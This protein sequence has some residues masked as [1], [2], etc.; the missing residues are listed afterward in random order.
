[1]RESACFFELEHNTKAEF[2]INL[3]A[4]YIEI[5]KKM[6]MFYVYLN[7]SQISFPTEKKKSQM[8]EL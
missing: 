1:L 8:K 7:I 2:D 3:L 5:K 4:I 6:I